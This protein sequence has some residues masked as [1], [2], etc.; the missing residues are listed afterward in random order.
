MPEKT[1]PGSLFIWHHAESGSEAGLKQWLSDLFEKTGIHGDLFVRHAE[2]KS[3]F[4]ETY[5]NI[6]CEALETIEGL[7]AEQACFR[8]VQRRCEAF[9]RIHIEAKS[10]KLENRP[11]R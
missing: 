2:G 1:P 3:T 9:E 5:E 11:D 8:S 4:M 10:H 7:A 6:G